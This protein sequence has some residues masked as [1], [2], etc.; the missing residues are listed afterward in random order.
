M[1]MKKRL[2]L[3]VTLALLFTLPAGCGNEPAGQQSADTGT[4]AVSET[5]TA[6]ETTAPAEDYSDLKTVLLITGSDFQEPATSY[7]RYD[8]AKNGDYTK[9]IEILDTII[10]NIQDSL[11]T[12]AYFIGGGDYDFDET[13]SSVP[14]TNF[15][16]EQISNTVRKNCGEDVGITI[17]QGNHDA[18]GSDY[19]P[20]G[21]ADTE[22]FG[23]FTITQED[24]RS[25]PLD[26][27]K[28]KDPQNSEAKAQAVA[29]KLDA[30][31]AEKVKS[32]YDKPVFIA[33][34]V[35]IHFNIRTVTKADAIYGDVIYNVI[36]KYGDDLNIIFLYG[37]NHAWGDDD[38]LGAASNFLTRGD[39]VNIAKHGSQKEFT[40]EPLN[41]TY[42]N[43]GYTGYFWAKWVS[44][45]SDIII[46]DDADTDL[47]MTA[48]QI[49]G[50]QV[51]ISRWD[52][53][54]MHDL[55]SVGVASLGH[56]GTAEVC[57][58]DPKVVKSP[59]V[60]TAPKNPIPPV[61]AG[62]K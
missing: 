10:G 38:Y 19:A 49:C 18:A 30:Y 35:P 59:Y 12:A 6:A 29:D 14:R 17:V 43:Y 31:L 48:F 27:S 15:G 40:V 11:G 7:T 34:H 52:E 20:T 23:L 55:K 1:R 25:Y 3:F 8:Y 39:T 36:H 13:T 42:M 5:T 60:V 56:R 26:K 9:Q 32:E 22:D 16:I 33:A 58:P 41:F 44:K 46:R 62:K 57:T 53:K 47:T 50:N 54:G 61:S 28:W 2:A 51:T 21:P 4:T 24:Y 37:H 45:T